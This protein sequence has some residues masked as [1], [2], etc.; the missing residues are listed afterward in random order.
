MNTIN[1]IK[2]TTV[3]SASLISNKDT[4]TKPYALSLK[5][6]DFY[7]DSNSKSILKYVLHILRYIL[8]IYLVFY[9]IFL[10]LNQ[11]DILPIWFK[12]I[13]SPVDILGISERQDYIKRV[14]REKA[15][16]KK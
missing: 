8:V 12:N 15:L 7:N 2:A 5:P 11:L 3:S 13:F 14:E 10:I 6:T 4:L 1:N 9:V 16:K